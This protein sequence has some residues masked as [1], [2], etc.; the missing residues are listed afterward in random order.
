MKKLFITA[1]LTLMLI[2]ASN[3]HVFA[4]ENAPSGEKTA[5][6]CKPFAIQTIKDLEKVTWQLY[7]EEANYMPG[8]DGPLQWRHVTSYRTKSGLHMSMY[9]YF[10]RRVM[11]AWA[12]ST[13]QNP[14]TGDKPDHIIAIYKD[15]K[16]YLANAQ[17]PEIKLERDEND[18]P[19]S[20]TLT[21]RD[22]NGN[23]V[24]EL[25]INRR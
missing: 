9:D 24:V 15:G 14:E 3:L 21:L 19:A 12:C 16:F 10:D 22:K 6:A 17:A 20:I 4:Q 1:A 11:L 8:E 7:Y 18:N 23:I 2:C 5:M 13:G 25:T